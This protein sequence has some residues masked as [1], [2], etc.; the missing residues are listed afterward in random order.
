MADPD[1]ER[2]GSCQIQV[3][4]QPENLYVPDVVAEGFQGK[5]KWRQ[6]LRLSEELTLRIVGCEG[7]T[8]RK[9]EDRPGSGAKRDCQWGYHLNL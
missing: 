3:P 1:C 5:H 8:T 4:S 7:R 9:W 6:T 2:I